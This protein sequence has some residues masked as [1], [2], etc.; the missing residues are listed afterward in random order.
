MVKDLQNGNRFMR[1]AECKR[2]SDGLDPMNVV[3]EVLI[4][5]PAGPRASKPPLEWLPP[6]GKKAT[7]VLASPAAAVESVTQARIRRRRQLTTSLAENV[8]H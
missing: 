2:V 8:S 5:S 3:R 4:P 1:H 7:P 6:S